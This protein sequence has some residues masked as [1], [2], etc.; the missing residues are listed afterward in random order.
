MPRHVVRGKGKQA[1]LGHVKFVKEE[2]CGVLIASPGLPNTP[3]LW[4]SAVL[5]TCRQSS[6]AVANLLL[7]HRNHSS[8]LTLVCLKGILFWKN[9][10]WRKWKIFPPPHMLLCYY[11]SLCNCI[12]SCSCIVSDLNSLLGIGR[13]SLPNCCLIPYDVNPTLPSHECCRDLSAVVKGWYT[14]I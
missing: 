1:V 11:C 2:T 5:L 9:V 13:N 14:S 6:G 4:T 8:K 3:F 12:Y 7:V 10:I